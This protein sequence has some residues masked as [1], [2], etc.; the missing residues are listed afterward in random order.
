MGKTLWDISMLFIH[1]GATE[2]KL[3]Q[4]VMFFLVRS[5][6]FMYQKPCFCELI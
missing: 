3:E 2:V 5:F 4:E 1:P 6:L